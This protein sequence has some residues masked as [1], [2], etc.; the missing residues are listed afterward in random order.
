[1]KIVVTRG[2][3]ANHETESE[4]GIPTTVKLTDAT[5]VGSITVN[6]DQDSD[7]LTLTLGD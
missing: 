4:P 1:M 3:T 2:T 5:N 6:L 7:T